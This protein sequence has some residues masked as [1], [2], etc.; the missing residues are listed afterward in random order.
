MQFSEKLLAS[1]CLLLGLLNKCFATKSFYCSSACRNGTGLYVAP[2]RYGANALNH[3]HP[4]RADAAKAS[5]RDSSGKPAAQRGLLADSPTRRMRH[6]NTK[7]ILR[8]A[9]YRLGGEC[10]VMISSRLSVWKSLWLLAKSQQL[11][12]NFVFPIKSD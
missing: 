8:Q 1:R 7:T 11:K 6:N 12:P 2:L 10:I 4:L 3:F 5:A 9:Q